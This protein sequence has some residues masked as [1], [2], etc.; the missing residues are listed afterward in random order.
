VTI[1]GQLSYHEVALRIDTLGIG[2][3]LLTLL[4]LITPACATGRHHQPAA[5]GTVT[6]GVTTTGAGVSTQVYRVTIE[7]GG[8]SGSVKA[9]AGVFTRSGVAPGRYL[10]RLLDVPPECRVD[11]GAERTLMISAERP[12]AVLRF[13]V[14]CR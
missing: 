5:G 3:T 7:P 2:V 8:I 9:D 10:V 12:S 6:I 4:T 11:S 14:V 13:N 1:D